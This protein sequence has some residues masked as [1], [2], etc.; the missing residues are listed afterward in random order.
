MTDVEKAKSVVDGLVQKYQGMQR[1]MQSMANDIL[2]AQGVYEYELGK[3]NVT[4]E[5]I[6][7]GLMPSQP[8]LPLTPG[9]GSHK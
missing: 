9:P 3:L 7:D 2:K 8:E 1:E 6:G 4:H 5:K